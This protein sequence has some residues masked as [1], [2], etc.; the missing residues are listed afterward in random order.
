MIS[1]VEAGKGDADGVEDEVRRSSSKCARSVC[2]LGR[3]EQRWRSRS[4][5]IRR[6]AL[7]LRLLLYDAVS[8]IPSV[9]FCTGKHTVSHSAR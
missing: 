9:V 6:R 1:S 5:Q 7:N 2:S 3:R 8:L 4:F